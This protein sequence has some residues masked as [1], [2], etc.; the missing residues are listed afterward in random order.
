[1][2][3]PP[4]VAARRRG[5]RQTGSARADVVP[6]RRTADLLRAGA[7]AASLRPDPPGG[8]SLRAGVRGAADLLRPGV[9]GAGEILGA[10]G[11]RLRPASRTRCWWSTRRSPVAPG[12]APA[13]RRRRAGGRPAR[14]AARLLAPAARPGRVLALAAVLAVLGWVA[15]TQTAVQSDVT[16]LVPTS[17]PA[18]RN[19]NTL[20]QVTGVSGEIDVTVRAADV[21]TPAIVK[22]MISYENQLL[23]PLRLRRGEGLR[24]RHPVPGPV[25]ARPVLHRQPVGCRRQ[26]RASPQISAPARRRACRTSRRR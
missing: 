23:T 15:D 25:A 20:E 9:R 12:I 14:P 17:M 26:P 13:G 2:A 21:A 3:A 5:S 16:K 22:W 10:A 19:L 24:P 18:L 4:G 1:M 11:R 7:R 8:R 6:G